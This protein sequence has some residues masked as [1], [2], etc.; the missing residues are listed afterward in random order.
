MKNYDTFEPRMVKFLAAGFAFIFV[1]Y[2]VLSAALHHAFYVRRHGRS[3]SWRIQQPAAD[4][5]STPLATLPPV[6]EVAL[7]VLGRRAR[8]SSEAGPQ[9]RRR[10]PDH[11]V[12]CTVNLITASL[13]AGAVFELT[14]RGQSGI[15]FS[16]DD[17]GGWATAFL[18]AIAAVA[19]Q[20]VWEYYWHRLMHLPAFYR[21]FHKMH[22]YYKS[23][24]PFDDMYIHPLEALGY[25]I[26][27]YSPAF[28]FR[29]HWAGFAFY[30][31]LMGTCGVL[32]HC[33]I[34]MAAGGIYTT[35]DHDKHHQ[36]F[37][38]NFA[39]PFVVMDILHGTFAG[40]FW[41]R[42]YPLSDLRL[43]NKNI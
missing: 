8:G 11:D 28:V 33:G 12:V 10:A 6:F 31:A 9:C 15:V 18:T 43:L 30:M 16:L 14:A 24:Q 4:V 34:R 1:F 22:H 13:A 21:R 40:T 38:C 41:G 2:N 20:L 35:E 39:F 3:G 36:F 19:W 23:P 27:L 17:A 42:H 29:L 25:Y 5:G 7:A 32:D 37:N 26:I